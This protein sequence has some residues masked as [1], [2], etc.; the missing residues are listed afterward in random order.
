MLF[1]LVILGY[2][3]ALMLLFAQFVQYFWFRHVNMAAL[4]C[5]VV[6]I[7]IVLRFLPGSR[8]GIDHKCFAGQVH[9]EE[10]C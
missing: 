9:L 5:Y 7:W 10:W 1:V 8:M 3:R 6:P 2:L 4:C